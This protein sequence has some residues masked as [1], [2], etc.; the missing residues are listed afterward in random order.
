VKACALGQA[1]AAIMA[2]HVIGATRDELVELRDGVRR[3]LKEGASPPK[4]RFDE[5][6]FLE[7]VRDF[8]ARHASTL[9]VFEAT[10]EAFDRAN[11]AG[12]S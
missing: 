2:R 10:V 1:S 3:M 7:P 12:Q 6:R 9:L 8:K 5:V 4:G 11:E